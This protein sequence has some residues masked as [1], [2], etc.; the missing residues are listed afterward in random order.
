MERNN[1]VKCINAAVPGMGIEEKEIFI[2]V[3]LSTSGSGG[4]GA[5]DE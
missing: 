4:A 5:D 1:S 3:K 2:T